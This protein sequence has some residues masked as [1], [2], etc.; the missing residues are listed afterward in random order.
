VQQFAP[1]L[2]QVSHKT[3]TRTVA[4][5][6]DNASSIRVADLVAHLQGKRDFLIGKLAVARLTAAQRTARGILLDAMIGD[7]PH[8]A[9]AANMIPAADYAAEIEAMIAERLDAVEMLRG[10]LSEIHGDVIGAGE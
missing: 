3:R 6:A 7:V 5:M 10:M 2:S 9:D 8:L 1:D 4:V